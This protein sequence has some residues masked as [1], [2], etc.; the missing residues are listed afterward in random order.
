MSEHTPSYEAPKIADYGDL[1]EITA[2]RS[3]TPEV[4]DGHYSTNQKVKEPFSLPTL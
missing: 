3:L 2:A 4:I 1:A